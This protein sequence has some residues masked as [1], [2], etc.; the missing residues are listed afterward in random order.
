M[1][2]AN[3]MWT[4]D[5]LFLREYILIP[6]HNKSPLQESNP[7]V[8]GIH[9]TCAATTTTPGTTGGITRDTEEIVTRKDVQNSLKMS[10]SSSGRSIASE[11]ASL[12]SSLSFSSSSTS[13]TSGKDFLSKFD[14]S[15]AQIKSNVQRLE[16]TSK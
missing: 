16:H 15:L 8:N 11:P 3:N 7:F 14:S 6:L 13:D 4:N 1:K 2:R 10:R 9:S 5:S 12:S